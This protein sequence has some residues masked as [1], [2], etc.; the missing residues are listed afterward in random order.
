[1]CLECAEPIQEKHEN[2]DLSIVTSFSESV[3]S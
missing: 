3:I 1:M 2:I